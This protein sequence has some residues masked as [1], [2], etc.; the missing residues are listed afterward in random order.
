MS[1]GERLRAKGEGRIYHPCYRDKITRELKRTDVWWIQFH[2]PTR[3]RGRTKVRE[4]AHTTNKGTA[5]RLLR[6][7]LD[8]IARGRATGPNVEK[9]TLADL[10]DLIVTDYKANG[11]RSLGRIFEALVHLI[12]AAKKNGVRVGG[13]FG[14]ACKAVAVTS[15]RVEA[16]KVRRLE[17]LAKPATINRELACLRRMFR[18]GVKHR[19][20]AFAP[21]VALLVER[22]TRKGFLVAEQVRRVAAFLDA[23][24]AAVVL[25]AFIT[26]WRVRRRSS[27][28]SG[29]STRDGSAW[30]RA[31]RRTAR[32]GTSP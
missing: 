22:N 16:Y 12:G 25:T 11:R 29:S 20:V 9:T 31:R 26:G 1:Q 30:S 23:P 15:D 32:A 19:K 14:A 5:A 4:S 17:E 7:R 2:D 6:R 10:A 13:Y 21:E 27:P 18:L 8:D 3:E 24:V 28:A